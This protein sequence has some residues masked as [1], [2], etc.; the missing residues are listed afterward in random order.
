MPPPDPTTGM[1][2]ITDGERRWRAGQQ[3]GVGLFPCLVEAADGDRAFFEA[4]LANLHRDALS[5]V[6]ASVGLQ[7][8]R[9]AFRLTSDEEV[10]TRLRK[11]R[12]WVR[13]MNAVLGLD[14]ETR[15]LMQERGEPVAIAVGLRPQSPAELRVTLDA[16]ADLPSRDDKVRFVSRVNEQRR[17]GRSIEE[18]LAIVADATARPTSGVPTPARTG[19]PRSTADAF[20]WRED[21]QGPTVEVAPSALATTRL[22]SRRAVQIDEWIGALRQDLLLLAESSADVDGASDVV[23][24]S[25]HPIRSLLA[26]FPDEPAS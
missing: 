12:G 15:A 13:Q 26:M 23:A 18:A 3:A 4:Y 2:S 6:D 10:A 9:E 7:H 5:P 24:R 17:V 25:V 22:A 11:S 16:I 19:R 14:P 8:I 1:H 20:S 21:D